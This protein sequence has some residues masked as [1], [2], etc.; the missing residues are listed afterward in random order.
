MVG[1][2]GG[3]RAL[4]VAPGV[5]GEGVGQTPWSTCQGPSVPAIYT[6]Q[7]TDFSERT[8]QRGAPVPLGGGGESENA[9]ES[10]PETGGPRS[11]C[12]LPRTGMA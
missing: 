6:P 10:Q 8:S 4:L 12:P 3:R 7:P 9:P 11:P 2:Q 1:E 5:L